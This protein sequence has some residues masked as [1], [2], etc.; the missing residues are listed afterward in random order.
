MVA[1]DKQTL[2][3]MPTAALNRQRT[4]QMTKERKPDRRAVNRV[5][6]RM[7]LDTARNYGA[8]LASMRERECFDAFYLTCMTKRR[9]MLTEA[10]HYAK[11]AKT[12]VTQL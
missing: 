6:A 2:P 10:L 8:V 1:E 12:P 5:L 7:A 9:E 4:K 11:L 3:A